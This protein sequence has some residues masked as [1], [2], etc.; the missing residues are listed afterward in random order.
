MKG[1][2]LLAALAVCLVPLAA[3]AD[4]GPPEPAGPDAADAGVPLGRSSLRPPPR[5]QIAADAGTVVADREL[6]VVTPDEASADAVAAAVAPLGYGVLRRQRL[7]GLGQSLLVLSIPDGRSGTAAIAEVEALDGKATVGVNHA[8]RLPRPPAAHERFRF[9]GAMI[10]WPDD[11]CRAVARIGLVDTAIDPDAGRHFAATI[12]AGDFRRRTTSGTTTAHG[13]ALV[14]LLA[15]PGR[16]IQPEIYNAVVVGDETDPSEAAGVDDMMRALDWL[17]AEG[18]TVVN[19]SLAGPYNKI[20]DIGVQAAAQR[21]LVI[22]A[23]AGNDGP[24]ALPRYPAAFDEVIAVTAVDAD[25]RVYRDAVRGPHIDLSAPGVDV[26]V[27]VGEGLR[28]VSG[29]SVAAPF[30]TALVAADPQI[31]EARAGDVLARLAERARDIGPPG[32]DD[33]FGFGL[34]SAEGRCP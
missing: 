25:G 3:A 11:G 10:E 32:R 1:L 5:A 28:F 13:T 16:L 31:G 19:L 12:R 30:V 14:S 22:V 6:V 4:D 21:G 26:A 27:P 23:A 9:A 18:V 20:L 2:L 8:Y 15:G 17:A 33:T 24:D 34:V 29:T 7:E